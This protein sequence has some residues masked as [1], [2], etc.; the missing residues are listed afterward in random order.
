MKIL[1]MI[2]IVV[3][4]LIGLV[5]I[6]AVFV[7]KEMSAEREVTINKTKAEVFNYVKYL[8]NQNNYSK[9]GSMDPAMKKEFKGTDGTVGFVSAWDSD[10]KDVG[11]GEQEITKIADGERVDYQLRFIKPWEST[12]TSYMTTEAVSEDQTKVKWGFNGK[13]N[14]PMNIMRL[15]MNMDDMIGNDFATGLNNLKSTLEKN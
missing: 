6:T 5:L 13:M 11:K 3:G 15:F 7:K 10:K 2:L 1:K 9:W 12:A 14:Y 8:K 4:V